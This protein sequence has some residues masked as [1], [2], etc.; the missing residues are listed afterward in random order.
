MSAGQ[1]T[2]AFKHLTHSSALTHTMQ[3]CIC[4]VLLMGETVNLCYACHVLLVHVM[5]R[6]WSP[7]VH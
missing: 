5:P 1:R 2:S 7:A 6:L 3:H 4:A